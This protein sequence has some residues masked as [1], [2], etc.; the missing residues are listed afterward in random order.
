MKRGRRP[1][2]GHLP[3]A[4]LRPEAAG[5]AARLRAR[6]RRPARPCR[7]PA[8]GDD[9]EDLVME[10]HA[11]KAMGTEV[12]LLLDAPPG[13]ESRRPSP[14]PSTSSS[15][16]KP[17]YRASA[18]TPSSRRSN[19]RAGSTPDP[20]SPRSHGSPSRR[21]SAPAA[22]S[23]RRSRA[24]CAAGYDRTSTRSSPTAP[25]ANPAPAVAASPRRPHRD[26]A[27]LPG[28][29]RDRQGL[30]HQPR[31]PRAR[32][33]GALPRTPAATSRLLDSRWP[34]GVET[35]EGEITL[36]PDRG[37]IGG[38]AAT[39]AAGSATAARRTT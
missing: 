9:H 13:G 2:L 11:F 33:H 16:W 38:Q 20:S 10:K 36:D 35:A 17:C 39:A 6:R 34:V 26:R 27:G 32:W 37:A 29:R 1:A 21:A 30:H 25:P 18:L 7:D 23:T 22:C 3:R 14:R 28:P 15:G 8:A 31:R 24:L 4:A 12:E 5:G 19:A